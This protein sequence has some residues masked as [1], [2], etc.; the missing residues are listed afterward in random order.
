M[1]VYKLLHGHRSPQRGFGRVAMIVTVVAI[2]LVAWGL[3]SRHRAEADL[4]ELTDRQQVLPVSVINPVPS[5]GS[6]T[7]R[8]P[9]NVQA[10][11]EAP[12][13]ART[14]GYL[15]RWDVDIG[16]SVQRGQKLAEIDAPELDQQLA[17]ARADLANVE[18]SDTIAQTTA[19]RWRGLR[20]SD[21][22]SQQEADEKISAAAAS[23]ASVKAARA[24]VR[25]LQEL[26]SY[27]TIVAPFAGVVTARNTDV[28]QLIT[29]G[30]SGNELF[31]VAD[32][33]ELRIYVRVPQSYANAMKPGVSA[34]LRFPDHPRQSY[35]AQ[36]VRTSGAID[37][38]SR[39]LLAELRV[40]NRKG[41][42]LPGGY[43]EVGF[44]LPAGSVHALR[45]PSNTV[46]FRGEGP[47]IATVGEG[48]RVA[49]KKITLG[50]DFGNE[51]EIV[52]GLTPQDRVIL[53]P[54]DSLIDS[55]QV[56]V[57]TPGKPKPEGAP[58]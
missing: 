25:R 17:Q 50:R 40:D 21:S 31:R 8:L 35:T 11:V 26:S 38:E 16:D 10:L 5:D 2:A 46:L 56:R 3:M 6:Q 22:V 58:S 23:A 45:V 43:T 55:V 44:E 12:I 7:L 4:R 19:E 54:A 41:E 14:S 47:R 29:E 57:V 51:V 30:S 24:N 34:E 27:K 39:T 52:E 42:L 15:K 32:M 53:S 36:L 9:G 18:A 20:D 33:H 48:D 13:Y 37:P 49:L 28:G 1:Y